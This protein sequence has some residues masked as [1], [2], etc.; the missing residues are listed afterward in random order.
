[1]STL[2]HT[3]SDSFYSKLIAKKFVNFSFF[4]FFCKIF[5]IFLSNMNIIL[6]FQ[7]WKHSS[8]A[9]FVLYDRQ[10]KPGVRWISCKSIFKVQKSYFLP[11]T[12]TFLALHT[13]MLYEVSKKYFF[14]SNIYSWSNRRRRF[15]RF[16]SAVRRNGS[17]V[18]CHRWSPYDLLLLLWVFITCRIISKLLFENSFFPFCFETLPG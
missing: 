14:Q 5:F 11:M 9:K 18:P 6:H 7:V 12:S 1:M 8:T 17:Y 13:K 3:I 2:C 15:R 16:S 4:N 10:I